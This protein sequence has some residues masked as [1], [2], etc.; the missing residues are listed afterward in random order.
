MPMRHGGQ[1]HKSPRYPGLRGVRQYVG[2]GEVD[3]DRRYPECRYP[4]EVFE[5]RTGPRT[6]RVTDEQRRKRSTGGWFVLRD[7][8]G[9]D[10]CRA[11][12]ESEMPGTQLSALKSRPSL[13]IPALGTHRCNLQEL[14]GAEA[15][16]AVK[17]GTAR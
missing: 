17:A 16:G 9:L 12:S 11:T 6:R 8:V 15:P 2:F 13:F 7:N 3:M 10:R 1:R 14:V 5:G 4:K